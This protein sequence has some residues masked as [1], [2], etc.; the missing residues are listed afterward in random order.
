MEST[1]VFVLAID[2]GLKGALAG[3]DRNGELMFLRD[4]P[5]ETYT[6]KSKK[7]KSGKAAT[8]NRYLLHE[9]RD[10]VTGLN[11]KHL[12]YEQQHPMPDQGVTSQ[13]TTGYGMGMLDMMAACLGTRTIVVSAQE[14]TKVM[15]K[16]ASGEGKE[17]A[18][19]VA[20]SMFPRAERLCKSNGRA[21][22]LCVAMY[23]YTTRIAHDPSAA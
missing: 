3:L 22:A 5:T 7:T 13:Y 18:L 6:L 21:D 9:L 10:I 16:G 11:P 17:R 20:R 12:V 23:A 2:P 8:R 4:M 15:L 1:D 19:G 14:W